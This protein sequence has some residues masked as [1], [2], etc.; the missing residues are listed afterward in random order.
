VDQDGPLA[1]L[2]GQI[3]RVLRPVVLDGRLV[4]AL[5]RFLNQR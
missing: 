3:A 5:N 2:S 1:L 4:L